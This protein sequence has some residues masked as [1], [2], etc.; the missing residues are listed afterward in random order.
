MRALTFLSALS[1]NF[2]SL[3]TNNIGPDGGKAFAKALETNTSLKELMYDA[4]FFQFE[5]P[6]HSNADDPRY[7]AGMRALTFLSSLLTPLLQR[8]EE[9]PRTGWRE[10]LCK[11]V[12]NEQILERAEVRCNFFS[13]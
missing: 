10:G 3:Y 5:F 12:G 13:I 4:T 8:D 7:A 11:G 2:Y 1:T 9:Q 6:T